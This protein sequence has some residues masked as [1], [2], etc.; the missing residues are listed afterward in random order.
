VARSPEEWFLQ[1][2]YD[3]ATADYLLKGRGYIYALFMCH[4]SVE[5][6]LKGLLHRRLGKAPPKTH[7]LLYLKVKRGLTAAKTRQH[8]ATGKEFLKWLK[9]ELSRP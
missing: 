5:K 7:D 4:L 3:M 1:A 8:L 6:A 9:K 2:R